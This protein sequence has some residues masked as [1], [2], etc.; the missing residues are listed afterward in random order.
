M[1]N[2]LLVCVFLLSG[3]SYGAETSVAGYTRGNQ[4]GDILVQNH[5][6]SYAEGATENVKL[7]LDWLKRNPRTYVYAKGK[8]VQG[9][10]SAV[11]QVDRYWVWL[12]GVVGENQYGDVTLR[13]RKNGRRVT[14]FLTGA[15]QLRRYRGRRV[16]VW[17]GNFQQGVEG[18]YLTFK[19]FVR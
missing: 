8:K 1:K 2:L 14:A 16:S 11:L 6:L 4:Y 13:Y 9:F 10:E 18:T 5:A 12:R 7:L 15:Q 3:F 17:V 19:G